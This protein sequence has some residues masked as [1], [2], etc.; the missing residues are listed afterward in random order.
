MA[1]KISLNETDFKI[2]YYISLLH[3]AIHYG[4]EKGLNKESY[5]LSLFKLH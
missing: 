4:R 3:F 1:I 2:S 5:N